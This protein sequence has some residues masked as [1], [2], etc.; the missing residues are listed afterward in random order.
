MDVVADCGEPRRQPE[1]GPAEAAFPGKSHR[2][3]F[4]RRVA[5]AD[6]VAMRPTSIPG[7]AHLTA[8]A[9]TAFSGSGT[10]F[11]SGRNLAA[12][13]SLVARAFSTGGKQNF[14]CIIKRRVRML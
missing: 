7:I 5:A 1:R 3:E 14:L 11:E 12:W 9:I 8:T 13:L 6:D 10:Q 2:T 4:G